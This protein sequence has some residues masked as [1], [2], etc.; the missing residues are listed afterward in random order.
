MVDRSPFSGAITREGAG[1]SRDSRA[2]GAGFAHQIPRFFD[3]AQRKVSTMISRQGVSNIVLHNGKVLTSAADGVVHQ[4][5]AVRGDSIQAVGSDRDMLSLSAAGTEAI[6]L[7]G[8]TVIP[9]IIDIH[10]HMD[11]EGLK[12]ACPSLEGLRS[13]D[14][15]LAAIKRLVDQTSPG[16]WVVT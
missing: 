13:I 4:A 5:L 6:D 10:A 7:Q 1:L 3:L 11:R 12:R 14:D 8:R 16:E 2:A 9:G 15:I